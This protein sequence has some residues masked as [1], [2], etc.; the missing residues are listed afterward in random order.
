MIKERV[1]REHLRYL[2]DGNGAHVS[3]DQAVADLPQK[4]LGKRAPG[5]PHTLWQLVEHL[6]IAQWDILEF[7]RNPRHVSP[8]FPKGYWP[9]SDSPASAAAW[10]RSVAGFRS[11]LAG[12]KKLAK[13]PALDLFAPLPHGDGQTLLREIL[14]AADHNAYHIGEIV[15]LRRSLGAWKGA[16]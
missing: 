15:I 7:S 10:K 5:V 16:R 2:L 6:R 11:D 9:A 12:L 1:L 3:F 8:E 4:L 13:D 14:L